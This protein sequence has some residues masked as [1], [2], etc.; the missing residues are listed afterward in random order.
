MPNLRPCN[1]VCFYTATW[2]CDYPSPA[3]TGQL[4]LDGGNMNRFDV[5]DGNNWVAA[6]FEPGSV[7][8]V[9]RPDPWQDQYYQI[10][11]NGTSFKEVTAEHVLNV[12]GKD[13]TEVSMSQHKVILQR[14]VPAPEDCDKS[15]DC[16]HGAQEPE[17]ISLSSFTQMIAPEL[18]E[19]ACFEAPIEFDGCGTNRQLVMR[20][21]EPGCYKLG[22]LSAE[23]KR[24]YR[25]HAGTGHLVVPTGQDYVWPD[26]FGNVYERDEAIAADQNG[27]LDE[28]RM[29]RNVV[30]GITFNLQCPTQYNPSLYSLAAGVSDINEA[31][32]T[33][34]VFS[35]RYRVDGGPWTYSRGNT[36]DPGSLVFSASY[37]SLQRVIERDLGTRSFPAGEI[38]YELLAFQAGSAPVTKLIVGARLSSEHRYNG[39]VVTLTPIAT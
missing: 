32:R 31:F 26:D 6:S 2:G 30:C 4:H 5:W 20:E 39:P 25:A 13:A 28:S 24:E 17:A 29:D 38:D 14:C 34:V 23:A 21:V 22:V 9:T 3:S 12:C 36:N 19:N 33:K 35:Y 37:N 11:S 16:L 8:K 18:F 1:T 7:I 15:C 10:N 27:T